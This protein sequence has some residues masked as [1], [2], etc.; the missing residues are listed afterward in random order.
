[1][2]KETNEVWAVSSFSG[3]LGLIERLGGFFGSKM[4]VNDLMIVGRS[5]FGT[6]LVILSMFGFKRKN[7]SQ[8]LYGVSTIF[9]YV[10]DFDH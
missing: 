8:L 5:L 4:S 2:T 7:Y 3:S 6:G 1:M 10:I 9:W